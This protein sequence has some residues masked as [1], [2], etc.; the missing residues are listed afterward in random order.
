MPEHWMTLRSAWPDQGAMAAMIE[1]VLMECAPFLPASGSAS[2]PAR[3][4]RARDAT[5]RGVD[6][7]GA[8]VTLSALV[9]LDGN[10]SE[11]A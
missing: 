2:W 3:F 6:L 8:I 10:A 1:E 4:C 9:V 5:L 11:A 7:V